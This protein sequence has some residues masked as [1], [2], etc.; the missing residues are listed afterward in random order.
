MILSRKLQTLGF[1]LLGVLSLHL[2]ACSFD[3]KQ[4]RDEQDQRVT[5]ENSRLEKIG[6]EISGTY[7]GHIT[8]Q[9]KPYE[10]LMTLGVLPRVPGAT[11][12]TMTARI[13][14]SDT[15]LP[16][17]AVLSGNYL[18]KG[19]LQLTNIKSTEKLNSFEASSLEAEVLGDRLQGT[20][21]QI[22]GTLGSF[23]VT[24]ISRALDLDS[25]DPCDSFY[26]T[27][28][29]KVE[30]LTGN[31][32]FTRRPIGW[33][34][35]TVDLSI[36][37]SRNMSMTAVTQSLYV[38]SMSLSVFFVSYIGKGLLYLNTISNGT[39]KEVLAIE[40]E[41]QTSSDVVFSGTYTSNTGRQ[42]KAE[43]R[44]LSEVPKFCP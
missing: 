38:D 29:P 28:R 36:Q 11:G 3:K 23:E 31:Y 4:V 12:T 40:L 24:R 10:I 1:I 21:N 2:T 7:E 20:I 33:A 26:K 17:D 19:K 30:E 44:K 6:K 32:E 27:V 9:G 37:A 14:R 41:K 5:D 25:I 39:S 15:I 13:K 34:P 8:I 16:Y 42:G 43:I 22:G 35:I 18:A